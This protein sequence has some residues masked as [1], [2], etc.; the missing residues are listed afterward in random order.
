MWPF[1]WCLFE[2]LLQHPPH[3]I[4]CDLMFPHAPAGTESS[5]LLKASNPTHGHLWLGETVSLVEKSAYY[6]CSYIDPCSALRYSCRD[7]RQWHYSFHQ[8][9]LFLNWIPTPS[10]QKTTLP[11]SPAQDSIGM[12]LRTP[13]AKVSS[14]CPG[15]F[16]FVWLPAPL[17]KRE[18][19]F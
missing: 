2:A 15:E 4:S 19:S 8:V 10:N 13:R 18:W 11:L 14:R 7:W 5:L 3:P 16:L 9:S 12:S 6:W 1:T 17:S